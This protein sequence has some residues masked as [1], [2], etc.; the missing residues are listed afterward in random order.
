MVRERGKKGPPLTDPLFSSP[1]FPQDHAILRLAGVPG[2]ASRLAWAPPCAGLALA[3]GARGAVAVFTPVGTRGGRAPPP[4]P[5]DGGAWEGAVL[6][7]GPAD[8]VAVTWLPP[9]S[10]CRWPLAPPGAGVDGRAGADDA[11]SAC[12][13][14]W[15]G[16]GA[17]VLATVDTIGDVRLA[18]AT[19]DGGWESA[20]AVRAAH[21]DDDDGDGTG[22][23]PAPITHADVAAAD[24]DG[25]HVLTVRGG[26]WPALVTRIDGDP[27]ARADDG[28]PLDPPVAAPLAA[29]ACARGAIALGASFLPDA[30]GDGVLLLSGDGSITTVTVSRWDA[31]PLRGDGGGSAARGGGRSGGTAQWALGA[32]WTLSAGPPEL[33]P[34]LPPT[35]LAVNYEGDALVRV[36]GGGAVAVAV[37]D[38]SSTRARAPPPPPPLPTPGVLGAA[39]G[40]TGCAVALT[41]AS[42]TVSIVRTAAAGDDDNDTSLAGRLT[43]AAATGR[44][45]LDAALALGAVSPATRAAA[46][47]ELTADVSDQP[48]ATRPAVWPPAARGALA[49]C[50]A[51]RAADAAAAP[52]TL[53]DPHSPE[54][55]L[56]DDLLTCLRAADVEAAARAAMAP[57][58]ARGASADAARAADAVALAPAAAWAEVATVRLLL[59]GRAWASGRAA[60]A[61]DA[62]A[63]PGARPLASSALLASLRT[64]LAAAEAGAGGPGGP[65]HDAALDAAGGV[66]AAW[67]GS[68]SLADRARLLGAALAAATPAAAPSSNS[69]DVAGGTRALMDEAAASFGGGGLALPL[70]R[71]GGGGRPFFDRR[72]LCQG[73]PRCPAGRG[74]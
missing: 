48:W 15:A 65:P 74:G 59:A 39:F 4:A 38:A 70:A 56:E 22:R 40:P 73:R 14:H 3:V 23:R 24:G 53:P 31:P 33:A 54:A 10:P 13:E 32:S 58:S 71:V 68:G 37:N 28:T 34:A 36:G 41:T 51:A 67:R 57:P 18:W 30:A 20:D 9:P 17:L 21:G 42:G 72:P 11:R 69:V 6:A 26:A 27:T 63:T 8:L 50:R 16:A 2:P 52:G 29:L 46:L 43:W 19:P 7:S 66:Y 5:V 60:G 35:I 25:V 44:S 49:V 64:A 12:V 61:A 45:P 47:A 1:P 55:A 62:D